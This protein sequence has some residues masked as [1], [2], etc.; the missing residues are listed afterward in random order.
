MMIAII[1]FFFGTVFGSFLNVCIYRLPRKISLITPGSFCPKCGTHIPWYFNI[2][3]ISY[4]IL[5]GE[6]HY[7]QQPISIRYPI[8]EL[9][10][11]LVTL[12]SYFKFGISGEFVFY[13]VFAYFLIVISFIDLSTQMIYNKLLVLLLV[14][15]VILNFIFDI[16]PWQEALLGV[17]SGM[18]LMLLFALIGYVLFRK[19]SLGMG[20]VKFAGVAGFFLGWKLIGVA[21]FVGFFLAFIFILLLMFSKRISMGVYIPMGP[22]L[23]LSILIFVYWGSS[24][25][26]L[27]LNW[28]IKNGALF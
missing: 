9:L 1:T 18:V 17:I 3:I 25:L 14:V 13:T 15:G 24:I 21:I 8:I 4:I 2:P 10:T 22:F 27:Y 5:R 26:Q 16:I 6:C 28:V 19:E 7:C 23:V 12:V 11:A 20:D